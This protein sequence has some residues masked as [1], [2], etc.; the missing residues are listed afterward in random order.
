MC[1]FRYV[2]VTTFVN[3]RHN[4]QLSAEAL[5][6]VT[7]V[8]VLHTSVILVCKPNEA[9]FWDGTTASQNSTVI[10]DDILQTH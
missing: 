1:R 10:D 9:L 6:S 5:S 3:T 4:I 7:C 2:F 8:P